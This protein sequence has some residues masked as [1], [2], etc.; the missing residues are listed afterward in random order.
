MKKLRSEGWLFKAWLQLIEQPPCVRPCTGDES[1][2][3]KLTLKGVKLTCL[4]EG[5]N[6]NSLDEGLERN[7]GDAGR[8]TWR[9]GHAHRGGW[10]GKW[11]RVLKGPQFGVFLNILF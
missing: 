9:E 1:L 11:G 4:E 8:G 7:K 5:G 6:V 3:R 10:R 2:P